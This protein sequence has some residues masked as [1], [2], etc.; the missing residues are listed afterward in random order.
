ML[1]EPKWTS[2]SQKDACVKLQEELQE[3]EEEEVE[4]EQ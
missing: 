3:E 2:R 4:E 1:R